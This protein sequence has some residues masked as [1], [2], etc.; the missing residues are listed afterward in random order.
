MFSHL[1]CSSLNALGLNEYTHIAAIR[2]GVMSGASSYI[3]CNTQT[4]TTLLFRRVR[5]DRFVVLRG[6]S[7]PVRSRCG[8]PARDSIVHNEF[9]S[10]AICFSKRDRTRGP[11]LPIIDQRAGPSAISLSP[12]IRILAKATNSN[13]KASPTDTTSCKKRKGNE[14]M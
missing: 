13:G 5:H 14:G 3:A 6:Q 1:C 12:F 9:G 4:S 2:S 10:P 11:G 8:L 7:G